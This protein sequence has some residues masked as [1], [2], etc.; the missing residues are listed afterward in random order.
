MDLVSSS[1]LDSVDSAAVHSFQRDGFIIHGSCIFRNPALLP[2]FHEQLEGILN[3]TY[4]T[5]SPPYKVDKISPTL[6]VDGRFSFVHAG[7]VTQAPA[8]KTQGDVPPGTRRAPT[9][10]AINVW[11]ANKLF[12]NLIHDA[13]LGAAVTRLM[14]WEPYGCR[15]AQ[16]QIWIKPPHSGA[17]TYHRDTPYLDFEP[18]QVCTLW[19]PFDA[20]STVEVGTLEY[21]AGSHRWGDERRGSAN[22]FYH[23]D[24][25]ALLHTAAEREI[26]RRSSTSG[27]ATLNPHTAGAALD[28]ASAVVPVIGE[29]GCC[30][31]HDGNTW[32]GSRLNQTDGWRRGIGIHYIRGDAIFAEK[33]GKLWDSFRSS[34]DSRELPDEHFPLVSSPTKLSVA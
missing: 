22:Q 15:V 25:T 23:A 12:S 16:D 20:V 1:L 24:Y 31:F 10:H 33:T 7:G 19:I 30:S 18:K 21:C 26:M 29:A 17:L 32:H 4:D 8:R 28:L 5:G 34:P 13:T 3:G 6:M 14:G 27:T 11:Q 2:L 9:I